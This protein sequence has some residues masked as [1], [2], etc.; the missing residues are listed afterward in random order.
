MAGICTVC[1]HDRFSYR[2][3]GK[4]GTIRA[5]HVKYI[6]G[7]LGGIFIIMAFYLLV[8]VALSLVNSLWGACW[9]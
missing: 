2:G 3:P 7:M 8:N 9:G 6:D 1:H 5:N 4:H